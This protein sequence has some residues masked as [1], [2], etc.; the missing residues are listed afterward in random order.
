MTQG[1]DFKTRGVVRIVE[2]IEQRSFKLRSG[3]IIL[4]CLRHIQPISISALD[5]HFYYLTSKIS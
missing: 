5:S 1:L 3:D 4:S 2:N